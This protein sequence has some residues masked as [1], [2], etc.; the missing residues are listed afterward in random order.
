MTS[1]EAR[2]WLARC[3]IAKHLGVTVAEVVDGA[4]FREDLKA[5]SLDIAGLA[6]ELEQAFDIQ[7]DDDEAEGCTTVAAA[8]A[9]IER[10]VAHGAR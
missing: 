8:V 9:L 5:D 10:K 3:T 2:E 4:R 7:I 1:E 6:N